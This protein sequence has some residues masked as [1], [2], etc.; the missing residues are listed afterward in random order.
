M[1]D[2]ILAAPEK[3]INLVEWSCKIARGGP[4]AKTP[5]SGDVAVITR[6]NSGQ[7]RKLDELTIR[8]RL[9]LD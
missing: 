6:H 4:L 7:T 5:Q 3:K 2:F 9:G 8:D 1:T